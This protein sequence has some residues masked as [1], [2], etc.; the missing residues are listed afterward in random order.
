M[1]EVNKEMLD[2]E[3]G[4]SEDNKYELTLKMSKKGIL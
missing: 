4:L 3:I 2:Y 1:T